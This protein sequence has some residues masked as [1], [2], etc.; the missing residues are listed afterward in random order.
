MSP[1]IK[2]LSGRFHF[3]ALLAD[4]R[5][6]RDEHASFFKDDHPL[7][8]ALNEAVLAAAR[9]KAPGRK[10]LTAD[11]ARKVLTEEEWDAL[12]RPFQERADALVVDWKARHD[13]VETELRDLA[14][15]L[16]VRPGSDWRVVHTVWSSTYSTQ[17]DSLGYAAGRARLEAAGL[18]RHGVE[19]DVV[20][21]NRR[22]VR[23]AGP[24]GGTSALADYEVHARVAEELDV[25]ILRRKPPLSLREWLQACLRLGRNPRVYLPGLAYGVEEQLG[26]DAFGNDVSSAHAA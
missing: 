2:R 23:R 25:E 21:T 15:R 16:E 24:F 13:A 22:E 8:I 6:L 18:S 17:T 9:A 20:E 11:L 14:A 26:L 10:R 3:A 19:V 12:R 1:R 4:L 7:N 5:A